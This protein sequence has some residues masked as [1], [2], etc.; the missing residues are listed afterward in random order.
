[1]ET[2][3]DGITSNGRGEDDMTKA[4]CD[5]R[6]SAPLVRLRGPLLSAM[7]GTSSRN[8]AR[9]RV[10]AKAAQAVLRTA[11]NQRRYDVTISVP[12]A[13]IW[14][15]IPKVASRAI[16]AALEDSGVELT[17]EHPY[18]VVVPRRLTD[19]FF[20]FAFTRDPFSRLVSCWQNKV[21]AGNKFALA[22]ELHERLQEFSAFVDYVERLDIDTCDPH[23]R[24]QS[25]L[26]DLDRVDFIGRLEN[27]NADFR[28]VCE[29]IGITPVELSRLNA[30]EQHSFNDSPALR[31][32][33]E[34][35]Y[36]D[37]MNRLT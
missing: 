10:S 26:I 19:T 15:R 34:A 8:P 35:I 32:R 20:K 3:P 37:D 31:R 6:V 14:Y 7:V 1:M 25:A 24:S 11:S 28:H 17:A 12:S 27:L 16:L 18:K 23:I 4:D 33:V 22:P 2:A 13:F 9:L 21:V 29:Q 36:R 5:D 30:S